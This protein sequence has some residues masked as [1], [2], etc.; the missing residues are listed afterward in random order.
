MRLRE[1]V[2]VLE[3]TAY[4]DVPQQTYL[5][6]PRSSRKDLFAK[7]MIRTLW[8]DKLLSVVLPEE[9]DERR[10]SSQTMMI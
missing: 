5:E 10:M 6:F 2:Q 4:N 8:I 9:W 7:N 3:Y 1:S